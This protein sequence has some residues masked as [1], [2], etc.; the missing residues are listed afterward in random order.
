MAMHLVRFLAH[1]NIP[2]R[3]VSQM[4]ISED[5]DSKNDESRIVE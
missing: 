2:C 4:K 1:V 3:I 5:G